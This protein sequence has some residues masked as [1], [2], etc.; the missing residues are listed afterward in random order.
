MT[1][2][3][4][5]SK[6]VGQHKRLAMGEPVTGMKTGGKAEKKHDSPKKKH[7]PAKKK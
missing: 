1:D 4:K 3:Q 5:D 6:L 2:N 7:T